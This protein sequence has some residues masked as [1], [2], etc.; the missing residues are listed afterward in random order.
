MGAVEF[1]S[2]NGQ[3]TPEKLALCNYGAPGTGKTRFLVTAPGPIGVIPLDR[4]ARGTIERARLELCPDKQIIFPKQDFIRHENPLQLTLMNPEES[5][6]YYRQHVNAIKRATYTLA[7]MPDSK[8]KTIAIDS[9]SQLFEDIF[10]ANY[11]RNLKIMPR[12]RGDSNQE[13]RDFLNSLQHKHL[14]ITHRASEIWRGPEGKEKPTGEF[15]HKGW[16]EI[17][18][19]VNVLVENA[20]NEGDGE[21]VMNVAM[22]QANASLHGD[23]GQKV[24]TGDAI[25]FQ[26]LAMLIFPESKWED[27]E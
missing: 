20:R 11:G 25:T 24:L 4:K 27:W 3:V 10:Y 21:F 13:M 7:E 19:Y 1:T 9:G 2:L 8:C 26:M 16:T 6:T 23:S 18:Y 15:K 17:G 22:C 12:D 14:I 5:K